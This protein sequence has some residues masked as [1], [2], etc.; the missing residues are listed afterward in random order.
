MKIILTERQYKILE[1]QQDDERVA[2]KIIYSI[3]QD[4]LDT[5]GEIDFNP[6]VVDYINYNPQDRKEI[7]EMYRDFL[8]GWDKMIEK[9]YEL[10]N[11]TFDTMDYD[12]RGGYNFK[13]KPQ[14]HSDYE[15]DNSTYVDCP[16]ESDGKVTLMTDGKTY[17]LKDLE[18]D[19]DLWWEV[20]GEIRNLI[21]D[22]LHKEVTKKTGITVGVNMCWIKE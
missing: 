18:R 4:E 13:F 12:F 20:E 15:E 16:I 9:S 17:L 3:W 14:F 22:I 10:M 21:Y 19:Y 6:N 7:Y 1:S 5:T 8:G 2:K 11:R